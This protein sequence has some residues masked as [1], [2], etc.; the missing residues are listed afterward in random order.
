MYSGSPVLIDSSLFR[1][2]PKEMK[3]FKMREPKRA[4]R[5]FHPFLAKSEPVLGRFLGQKA[6]CFV[7]WPLGFLGFSDLFFQGPAHT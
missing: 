2:F 7:N 4:V 5:C 1:D 3:A 6:R